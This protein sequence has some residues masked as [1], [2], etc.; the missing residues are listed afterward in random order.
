MDTYVRF[1][2]QLRCGCTGRPAG[3][4]VAAGRVEDSARLSTSTRELLRDNLAWFNSNLA[5]P[6][7][8]GRDWRCIFWFRSGARELIQRMWDLVAILNEEGVFV[9]KLWTSEPGQ[10]VYSDQYQIGAIPHRESNALRV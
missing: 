10:V 1:Q 8:E 5:V 4:F 3:L 9:R 6:S 7:L 2:T